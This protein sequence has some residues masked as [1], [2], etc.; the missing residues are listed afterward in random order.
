MKNAKLKFVCLFL[1]FMF[2]TA[3][4]VYSQN[5]KIFRN[6]THFSAENDLSARSEDAG[7]EKKL[8]ISQKKEGIL[9]FVANNINNR[10]ITDTADEVYVYPGGDLIGIRLDTK[11]VICVEHEDLMADSGIIPSPSESAGILPGDV[12]THINSL[13][14]N[15]A[16]EFE[17]IISILEGESCEVTLKRKEVVLKKDVKI[18]LC[19]DGVKRIGLWIRDNVMGLGTLSFITSDR[20]TFAALGH[21]IS[22]ANTGIT[23]PVKNGELKGAE[24]LSIIK[25]K[26]NHPGE[27]RGIIRRSPLLNAGITLNNDFGIYGIVKDEMILKGREPVAVAKQSEIKEGKAYLITTVD[28]VRTEYE[29]TIEE[30]YHQSSP[31]TKSMMIRITDDELLKKTGGII[32]GMSGSPIIQDGK[33]IGA[34]THVLT[35]DPTRGYA[36]FAEWMINNCSSC[37]NMTAFCRS[38][39]YNITTTIIN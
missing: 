22:D 4:S 32:Q 12:I 16:D 23:V 28:N 21:P 1:A 36:I 2:C 18:I 17:R 24:V 19:S 35:T 5:E 9:S 37:Q 15:D 11:G 10:G 6:E 14:V 30:I 38:D 13:E 8:K 3:L 39:I 26:R 20:T 33:L 25:G 7:Y 31:S 34:V 29:I 27:I